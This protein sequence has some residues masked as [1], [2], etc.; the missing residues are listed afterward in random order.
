ME[1][2]FDLEI[3]EVRLQIESLK[4]T[5]FDNLFIYIGSFHIAMA[6][7]KTI[8]KCIDSSGITNVIVR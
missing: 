3:A 2:T 6:H 7:F 1:V 5:L 4:R 8:G